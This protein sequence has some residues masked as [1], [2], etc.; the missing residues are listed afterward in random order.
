MNTNTDN[1][2][3]IESSKFNLKGEFVISD[4][5]LSNNNADTILLLETLKTKYFP[6]ISDNRYESSL[7]LE[8]LDI[9]IN[10][11]KVESSYFPYDI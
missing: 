1:T 4:I 8:G 2:L 6:L 11:N 9:Y 3:Q 5:L 7:F 10:N